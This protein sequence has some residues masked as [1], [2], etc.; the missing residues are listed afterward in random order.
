MNALTLNAFII[1]FCFCLAVIKQIKPEYSALA[2]AFVAI[3]IS[4]LALKNVYPLIE[5]SKPFFLDNGNDEYI[6][7]VMKALAVA[8]LSSLASE[9][10]RDAGQNSLAY[11][12]EMFCKCEIIAM[13]MPLIIKILEMAKELLS[14]DV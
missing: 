6:K 14:G 8:G 10:C 4:A 13:S 11:G 3:V 2:G 7:T 1:V 5:Y 9:I 12:V